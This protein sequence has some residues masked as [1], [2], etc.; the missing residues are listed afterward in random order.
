MDFIIV[1]FVLFGCQC[2]VFISFLRGPRPLPSS[3][4]TYRALCGPAVRSIHTP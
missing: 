1:Q 2:L 3:G 4:V